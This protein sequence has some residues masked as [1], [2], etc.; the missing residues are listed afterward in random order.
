MTFILIMMASSVLVIFMLMLGTIWMMKFLLKKFIGE[1][2]LDIEEITSTGEVPRN[3]STK[4]DLKIRKIQEKGA[5]HQKVLSLKQKAQQQYIKKI[6]QLE[7]YINKTNLV[8][9]ESTRRMVL[10]ELTTA[11]QQWEMSE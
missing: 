11:R 8:D 5:S 4:Y 7:K 10:K 9:S 3:W 6:K 1:K 2:H